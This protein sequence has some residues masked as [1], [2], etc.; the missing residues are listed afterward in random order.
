MVNYR[1][2]LITTNCD[3]VSNIDG[4]FIED[5]QAPD[6][7]IINFVTNDTANNQIKIDWNPSVAQDVMAYIIFKFSSGS[8]TPLDTIY[9]IQNTIYYDSAILL[10]KI[11]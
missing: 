9:G 11:V 4:G 2:R 5:Q 10:F 7:P 1:V 3:F 6:P 8:W